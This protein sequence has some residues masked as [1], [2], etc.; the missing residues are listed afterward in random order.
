MSC[1]RPCKRGINTAAVQSLR[2]RAKAAAPGAAAPSSTDAPV[3]TEINRLIDLFNTGRY[4]DLERQASALADRYPK[5][6]VVWMLLGASLQTQNKNGLPAL[7]EAAKLLPDDADAHNNLGNAL[8]DLGHFEEAVA[9]YR[10]ALEIAPALAEAYNNL[11]IAQNALRQLDAAV[12]SYRRA[13]EIKPDY[14]EAHSNLGL[15][16]QT[17]DRFEDAVA[18][19][20]RALE[21]N[22]DYADAH[23]NMGIYRTPLATRPSSSKLPPGAGAK[24]IFCQGAQ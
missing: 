24:T 10:R 8:K 11:G 23:N 19:C 12:A 20:R 17:L 6:G 9:S 14:A 2:Q 7:Q 15:T 3:P 16:L 21:I 18:S 4:G 13:L 22:P 1:R 5:C